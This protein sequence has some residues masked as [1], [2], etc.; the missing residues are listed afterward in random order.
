MELHGPKERNSPLIFGD[1][2]DTV[3]PIDG[4]VIHGRSGFREHFKKHRVTWAD[5]FREEWKK[6]RKRYDAPKVDRVEALKQ[7]WDKQ[8]K[9]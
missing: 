7:A 2:P 8:R 4:T 9:R 1:L 5:D 6:P 3:S